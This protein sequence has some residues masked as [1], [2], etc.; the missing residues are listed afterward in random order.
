M[1]YNTDKG[2]KHGLIIQV[3]RELT[4][5]GRS[6]ARESTNGMMGANIQETGRIIK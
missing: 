5:Q 3:I 2:L 4:S 1:I 6:M